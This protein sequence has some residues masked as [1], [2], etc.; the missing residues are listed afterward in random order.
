MTRNLSAEFAPR[1]IRVNQV[2]PGATRTPIWS[3]L[4][5]DAQAM[6]NLEERLSRSIPFGHLADAEDIARAT[7]Y[8]ASDDAAY[9]TGAEI[10]VDGGAT[11]VP[12]GA[13]IYRA[14]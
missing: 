14:A 3:P 11:G 2:T 9:V 10:V 5:P 4:A 7:L 12:Q 1:H 8:L 13:P 6:A